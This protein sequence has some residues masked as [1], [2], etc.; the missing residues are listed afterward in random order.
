MRTPTA[1]RTARSV[2]RL[3]LR[4]GALAGI[5][6]LLAGCSVGASH[7]AD[8][9][10]PTLAPAGFWDTWGDGRAELAG[11]TLTQPRYGEQRR[12]EA[13]L[14]FVTETFTGG[15]RVKSDGGHPD[16]YPV[17]KLNEV[18]DF[19]TGLYDYN[20]MTSSWLR[21]DGRIPLGLPDKVSFSMQEWCGHVY[22]ELTVEPEGLDRFLHSYFDGES[23]GKASHALPKGGVVADA[24]PMLVRNLGGTFLEPGERRS[25]PWLP[26]APERRMAHRGFEWTTATLSRSAETRTLE[27]PAGTFTVYT[28]TAEPTG[29]PSTTWSVDAAS[30]ALVGWRR[31]DGEVAELTGRTRR[32]YWQDQGEGAEALRAELGLPDR[33]WP[34]RK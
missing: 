15:Q 16:E 32:R 20:L 3:S 31:S 1:P 9:P 10:P 13:V 21:L 11:Y 28:V 33:N 19:Q 26:S 25:V 30:G 18:R 27:V 14:V 7:A 22:E 17:L 5:L 34:E 2:A 23:A 4:T 12:G 24:M 6:A 8:E 29:S